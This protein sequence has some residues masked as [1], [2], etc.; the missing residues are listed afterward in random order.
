MDRRCTEQ[1]VSLGNRLRRQKLAQVRATSMSVVLLPDM[2]TKVALLDGAGCSHELTL[3]NSAILA[4]G[5]PLGKEPLGAEGRPI[6]S[7]CSGH[8]T[9]TVPC[10]S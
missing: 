5:V 4:G 2:S 1:S 7:A 8:G 3:A 6:T 9:F 10:G